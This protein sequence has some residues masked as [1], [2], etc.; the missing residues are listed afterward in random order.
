MDIPSQIYAMA[1]KIPRKGSKSNKLKD[2]AI[3]TIEQTEKIKSKNQP[4]ISILFFLI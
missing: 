1:N 2:F 4:N 3:E